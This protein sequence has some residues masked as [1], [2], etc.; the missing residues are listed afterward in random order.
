[1]SKVFRS[2]LF[3]LPINPKCG[4]GGKERKTQRF[5]QLPV[6]KHLRVVR[7]CV[8]PLGRVGLHPTFPD[9]TSVFS[10]L[11][12][13]FFW[14]TGIWMYKPLIKCFVY[15]RTRAAPRQPVE[16][17]PGCLV[18]FLFFF[19]TST[20]DLECEGE[21]E[22]SVLR[23]RRKENKSTVCVKVC[24]D[25]FCKHYQNHFSAGLI[26]LAAM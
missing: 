5:L 18:F 19:F 7:V 22:N 12:G 4:E 20:V 8:F 15:P 16:T 24:I 2:Q 14:F 10:G 21:R 23:S 9:K 11:L 13:P 17:L 25:F 6:L 1:M 3:N 26:V